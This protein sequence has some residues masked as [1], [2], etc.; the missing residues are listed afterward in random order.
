MEDI[1]WEQH[2]SRGHPRPRLEAYYGDSGT[3]YRYTGSTFEPRRWTR[4]LNDLLEVVRDRV[5]PRVASALLFLYRSGGD[6]VSWHRDVEVTMGV[7]PA[8][9]AVVLGA[10]REVQF[11]RVGESAGRFSICPEHGDGYSL[12]GEGVTLMEHRVPARPRCH[13]PRIVISF[14]THRASVR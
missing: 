4:P 1:A 12:R 3:T 10:S 5:E 8:I 13:E 14:R 2:T 6:S 7:A 11:K 9:V